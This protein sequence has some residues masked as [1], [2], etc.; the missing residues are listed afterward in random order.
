[1]GHYLPHMP[2]INPQSISDD[3][4]NNI[5]TT[6]TVVFGIKITLVCFLVSIAATLV[7]VGI[8]FKLTIEES[9]CDKTTCVLK[10]KLASRI[11]VSA[12]I[13]DAIKNLKGK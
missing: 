6:R 13:S 9:G 10:V 11:S 8:F 1:M 12:S 2:R 3:H 5:N 4:I 7:I